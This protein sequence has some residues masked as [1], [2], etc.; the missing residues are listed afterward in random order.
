ME[1]ALRRG[2][3]DRLVTL[4]IQFHSYL[5]SRAG[6]RLLQ[7]AL[8]EMQAQVRYFMYL[9]RPGDEA[10]YPVMHHKLLEVLRSGDVDRAVEAVR[11]HILVT[12]ER[13]VGRLDAS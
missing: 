11:E 1:A 4:D 2:D 13:A 8:E 7:Q 5:W 6:H 12:A 9:T 3:V 10:G